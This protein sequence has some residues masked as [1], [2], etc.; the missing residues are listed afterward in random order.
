[1]EA[2]RQFFYK[3]LNK[4]TR[5]EFLRAGHSCLQGGAI[6]VATRVGHR[7]I[8]LWTFDQKNPNLNAVLLCKSLDRFCSLYIAPVHSAV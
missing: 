4:Q 8:E 6:E 5:K 3:T 2:Y 7:L 1:M